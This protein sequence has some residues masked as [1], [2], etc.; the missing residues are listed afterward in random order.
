M[1]VY[2]AA[3]Q[4]LLRALP[5]TAGPRLCKAWAGNPSASRTPSRSSSQRQD[6]M[7]AGRMV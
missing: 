3:F 4:Q 7:P 6:A 5:P 1:V 2:Q